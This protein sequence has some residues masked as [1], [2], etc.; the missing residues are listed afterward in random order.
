MPPW[1][2]EKRF[3]Q[4][5]ETIMKT[6][7]SAMSMAVLMTVAGAASASTSTISTGSQIT[8]FDPLGSGR[9]T[10]LSLVAGADTLTFSNAPFDGVDFNTLS[11][12]VAILD[13][14][15]LTVTPVAPAWTDDTPETTTLNGYRVAS[16]V[17]APMTSVA[18]DNVTGAIQT[19]SSA[20]GVLLEGTF[21]SG[22]LTGGSVGVNNMRF[23][24]A[25]GQVVADLIGHRNP[26]GTKPAAD[27]NSPDTVLWTFD[28]T[29]V[30]G[31]RTIRTEDLLAADPVAAMTAAGYQVE[32]QDGQVRYVAENVITGLAATTTGVIF[33]KNALGLLSTGL[34]GLNGVNGSFYDGSGGVG[35]GTV[36]SRL[37]FATTAV[38]EPST[39]AL[40]GLGLVGM[41]LVVRRQAAA[42]PQ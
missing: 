25:N 39:Y 36:T 40:M 31:P 5:G 27:Y 35:W 1:T 19:M 37:V 13:L 33:F 34:G 26:V 14:A 8:V 42:K 12:F 38:P 16:T 22:T 3:K 17:S 11:G 7:L 29:A 18:L 30:T 28:K 6:S 32:V 24:L 23:D 9:S 4:S 15:N 20:G 21:I 41:A 10:E 2:G